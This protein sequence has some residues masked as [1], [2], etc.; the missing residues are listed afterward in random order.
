MENL[1]EYMEHITI[2]N[3]DISEYKDEEKGIEYIVPTSYVFARCDYLELTNDELKKEEFNQ[4]I[5]HDIKFNYIETTRP[6]S[7]YEKTKNEA[8]R[9]TIIDGKV[10]V[11]QIWNVS[12]GL[13]IRKTFNNKEDALKLV[14]EI[15]DKVK[16]V[17]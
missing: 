12:N 10:K 15:N 16:K 11:N 3:K 2:I 6:M 5:E 13:K 17:I 14:K 7:K 8:D 9:W 1:I 4:T